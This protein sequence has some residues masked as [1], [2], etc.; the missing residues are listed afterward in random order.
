MSPPMPDTVATKRTRRHT[1][2]QDQHAATVASP[3]DIASASS[4][5]R[6]G[7][8]DRATVRFTGNGTKAAWGVSADP[9]D[10]EISTTG[11]NQLI[12][13]HPGDMTATVGAGMPLRHLQA[14]LA[15]HGQWLALDPATEP[16]GATIGG[17]LAAGDAGPRRLRYGTLRDLAIGATLV[18]ADGTIAHSG[19]HVIKNV[20]GYDLTKLFHGSLGSLGLIGEV[21][22]RLHPVPPASG[23]ILAAATVTQASA[24]TQSLAACG[25]EP[26]AIEWIDT[27][28]VADAG[29]LLVRIDGSPASVAAGTH[30]ITSLLSEHSLT[31]EQLDSA[32]A[33]EHWTQA[34]AKAHRAADDSVV[35]VGT[36]P[37]H[38]PQIAESLARL[39]GEHAVTTRLLSSAAL[40]LHTAILTG[41]PAAQAA[42]IAAWRSE[43]LSLGGA[44]TIRER[45]PGVDAE[46]DPLGPAPSAV[47]LLRAV[48]AQLDPHGRCA[49]GRFRGWY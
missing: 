25:V 48:K 6:G 49:P 18:L 10:L 42:V 33:A 2:T 13:H 41:P 3:P 4:L 22:V 32:N 31:S 46:L 26:S 27:A 47:D 17:L 5:L 9:V 12:T 16:V 45:P 40:G 28:T 8:D 43:V 23:T 19:S 39:A 15:E 14:L 35:R 24:A 38:L 21:I 36:L 11:L 29:T 20:A 37:T 34:T 1:A 30:R 44:V 7:A